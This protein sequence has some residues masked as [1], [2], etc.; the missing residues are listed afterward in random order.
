[1]SAL[2][3]L[4]DS[5]LKLKGCPA[6][7]GVCVIITVT[8]LIRRLGGDIFAI[9][10]YILFVKGY[11]W[12]MVTA[13]LVEVSF[14]NYVST[15]CGLVSLG[16]MVEPTYGLR[17][18]IEFLLVVGIISNIVLMFA[19]LFWWRITDNFMGVNEACGGSPLVGGLAVVI[20]QLIPENHFRL[21]FL[22]SRRIRGANFPHFYVG[23]VFAWNVV[24]A[25]LAHSWSLIFVEPLKMLLGVMVAWVYLRFYQRRD[26]RVG[27]QSDVF[28][29][30]TF[31]PD[32]A[33]PSINRALLVL[34]SFKKKIGDASGMPRP[35]HKV[36]EA[37][38]ETTLTDADTTRHRNIGLELLEQQ[39]NNIE[40]ASDVDGEAST[41]FTLA[42]TVIE[43]TSLPGTGGEQSSLQMGLASASGTRS[44]AEAPL[45]TEDM[46]IPTGPDAV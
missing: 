42:P 26:G 37:Y 2:D 18:M 23:S 20:K 38:K 32:N 11:G 12:T 21:V 3:T 19:L 9:S 10:P 34:D 14:F 27:D 40:A 36:R 7:V 13:S 31:F 5:A 4:R 35:R 6:L 15:L 1:M 17:K 39:M 41:T 24:V 30:V 25:L 22:G 29:F 46:S 16:I 44:T 45:E 8:S 33:Q 43:T 28:A